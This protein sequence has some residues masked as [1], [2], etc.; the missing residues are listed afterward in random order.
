MLALPFR[1]PWS[2]SR[3][4]GSSPDAV[5]LTAGIL[6]R[7]CRTDQG[8]CVTTRRGEVGT[9]LYGPYEWR[10]AGRYRVSFGLGLA[11]DGVAPVGD[12]V[13]ARLDV[14]TGDGA[15]LLAECFVLFSQLGPGIAVIELPFRLTEPRRVEYRVHGTGQVALDVMEEVE[16]VALADALPPRPARGS[17]ERGW[18]NERE[19]LD[20]Y[21]RNISG[22]IHIGANLGQE[23]RYYWLIGVDVLWIEP[24]R[25]IY[26][27]MV[28]N[29]AAYPRQSALNAL[30]GARDGEEVTLGIASNNG[31]S[32]SVL[33]LEEHAVLF[34]DVQYVEQRRLT[35]VTLG[36]LIERHGIRLDDYQALTLD[37]E[38]SEL[39]ILRGAGEL[40]K[41]FRYVKCEVADFPARTGT[42]STADL[43]GLLAGF[44]F[45]QLARRSFGLG[46][47]GV[48]TFW[49]IVWKREEPGEPLHEPGHAL[50]FVMNP[51][52]VIAVEKID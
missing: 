23:R 52:E 43:D 44:G 32:S 48:G 42:P 24:I 9:I 47:N 15:V 3:T 29:I 31:A 33:P 21:L 14:V 17:R 1:M 13:C 28:D 20:G 22:V 38:G 8:R 30:V 5:A 12:A 49:D 10:P 25:E 4:A 37:T 35:T 39:L 16:V 36:T 7:R 50:P 46:P 2:R 41:H 40:L 26:E 45:R 51:D 18:E 11:A 6:G 34:P 27:R 19:F